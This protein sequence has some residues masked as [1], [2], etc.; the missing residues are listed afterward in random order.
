MTT[1]YAHLNTSNVQA[2]EVLLKYYDLPKVVH[3]E[4]PAHT[5]MIDFARHAPLTFAKTSPMYVARRAMEARNIPFIFALDAEQQVA[6]LLSLKHI[7]SEEPIKMIEENRVI[8]SEV[9]IRSV[10]TPL[11][12]IPV[13]ELHKL[14]LAKVGHILKTLEREHHECLLVVESVGDKKSLRGIFLQSELNKLPV[15]SKLGAVE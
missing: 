12:E 7:L 2:S 15:K 1:D 10:M 4:D 13:I 5:V 11:S 8:R 14:D 9:L 3:L 6:G